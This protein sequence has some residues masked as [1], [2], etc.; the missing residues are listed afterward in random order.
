MKPVLRSKKQDL[1]K[2]EFDTLEQFVS[3][4]RV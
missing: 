3:N 1:G 4:H 2:A